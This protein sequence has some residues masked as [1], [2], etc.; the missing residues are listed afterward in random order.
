MFKRNK[1]RGQ[2]AFEYLLLVGGVL[3]IVVL[4]FLVLRGSVLGGGAGNILSAMDKNLCA[5]FTA[6]SQEAAAST[7]TF[8]S[9]IANSKKAGLA[10]KLSANA[11]GV[12]AG[13]VYVGLVA[14]GTPITFAMG[15]SGDTCSGSIDVTPMGTVRSGTVVYTP[16]V[17]G[18]ESVTVTRVIACT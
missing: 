3:V 7:V 5:G 11:G 6:Q 1:T 2:G 18:T 8:T 9:A 10:V 16:A 12:A 14:P 13:T 17:G 4:V 15:C